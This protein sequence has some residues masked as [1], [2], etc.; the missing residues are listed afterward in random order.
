VG[1]PLFVDEF[2]TTLN[3]SFAPKKVV[4]RPKIIVRIAHKVVNLDV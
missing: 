4:L 3:T 1:F 2:L